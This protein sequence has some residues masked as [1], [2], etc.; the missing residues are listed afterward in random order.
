MAHLDLIFSGYKEESPTGA[1]NNFTSR[2]IPIIDRYEILPKNISKI[3]IECRDNDYGTIG[4]VVSK[5]Y[6]PLKTPLLVKF[7][8]SSIIGEN[9]NSQK[10]DQSN[11]ETT[12]T[13]KMWQS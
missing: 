2:N 9:F 13:L 10:S 3:F 11:N 12:S 6:Q 5:V 7:R 8:N 4:K 1:I